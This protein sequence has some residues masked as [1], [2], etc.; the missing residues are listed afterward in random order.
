MEKELETI[1]MRSHL[2]LT[3]PRRVVFEVLKTTAT[4]LSIAS[5]AESCAAIDRT[6]V[7]RTIDMFLKLDIVKAVPFG[8]KQRYELADPFKS[9]HHHLACVR[10]GSLVDLHS[11]KIED[12]ISSIASEHGFR[13]VDHSVEIKGYCGSCR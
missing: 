4:P 7:Y 9:H 1:F 11:P 2:R 5:I 6:S 10:C 8:W 13:A 12:M 3:K